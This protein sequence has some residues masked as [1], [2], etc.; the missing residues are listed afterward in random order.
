[1]GHWRISRGICP[2]QS[3]DAGQPRQSL[4]CPAVEISA[5]IDPPKVVDRNINENVRCSQSPDGPDSYRCRFDH[6]AASTLEEAMMKM[7]IPVFQLKVVIN[8]KPIQEYHKDELTFVEGRQGSNF[9]LELRNLT[10]RRLLVHPTV[11]GLSA[12]NGKEAS[13]NDSEHGYVLPP[14]CTTRIPGWR[15][16]DKEVAAFFFAGEGKSYAEQKGG[17][18]DKGVIACAVWEEKVP[19]YRIYSSHMDLNMCRG[20]TPLPESATKGIGGMSVNCCTGE[21]PTAA[22]VQNL[23]AG[24]GER[25]EHQVQSTTFEPATT[26]PTCIA[27]IYYDD[28]QGLK[29]RGIKIQGFECGFGLPNP[30]PKDRGEGCE[31]PCDWD[32]LHSHRG[33]F[34]ALVK[35]AIQSLM[36]KRLPVERLRIPRELEYLLTKSQINSGFVFG[37]PF[38]LC[39]GDAIIA[40][41]SVAC[42]S[43]TTRTPINS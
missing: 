41:S 20:I 10:P 9:E 38:E 42:G 2:M 25:T 3:S 34:P 14:Y 12:M 31:P 5:G 33:P 6:S 15:L 37:V 13:K 30:F 16:S 39:D 22:S 29:A 19:E 35:K 28:L 40:V 4:C 18:R 26:E 24:F 36:K 1:V 27:V 23:G 32:D 7:S 21:E 43:Q 11:D 17:G 8:E